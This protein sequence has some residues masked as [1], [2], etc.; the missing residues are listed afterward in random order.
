MGVA[1][2]ACAPRAL[3]RTEALGCDMGMQL[4]LGRLVCHSCHNLLACS[5]IQAHTGDGT[6]LLLQEHLAQVELQQTQPGAQEVRTSLALLFLELWKL[7]VLLL[8]KNFPWTPPSAVISGVGLKKQLLSQFTMA[9][10][11]LCPC[12]LK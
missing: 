11:L 2:G 10:N 5:D 12:Q 3:R 1:P 7:M 6:P 9:V 8:P 4:S